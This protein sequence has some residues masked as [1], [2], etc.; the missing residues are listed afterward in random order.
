MLSDSSDPRSA[1]QSAV[2]LKPGLELIHKVS[3]CIN[4]SVM[5]MTISPKYAVNRC[6]LRLLNTLEWNEREGE[7]LTSQY[8]TCFLYQVSWSPTLFLMS[9]PACYIS[10]AS[11]GWSSCFHIELMSEYWFPKVSSPFCCW[12]FSLVT[13]P[14]LKDAKDADISYRLWT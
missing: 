10:L 9:R 4:V 7:M 11:S 6:L 1:I 2:M 14:K 8:W 5:H 3:W 13:F 12:D